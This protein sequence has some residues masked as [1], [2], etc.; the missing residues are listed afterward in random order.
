MQLSPDKVSLLTSIEYGTSRLRI[1]PAS[2][3]SQLASQ[4][5]HCAL[6]ML[7]GGFLWGEPAALHL[8]VNININVNA[9]REYRSWLASPEIPP[10][11]ERAHL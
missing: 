6:H 7:F 11:A 3:P 4:S 2:Q 8:F 9:P 1:P 10:I 5:K